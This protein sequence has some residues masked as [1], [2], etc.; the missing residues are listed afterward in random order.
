MSGGFTAVVVRRTPGTD[1]GAALKAVAD[2]D[3]SAL[4]AA[5]AAR[6]ADPPEPLPGWEHHPLLCPAETYAPSERGVAAHVRDAV[7]IVRRRRR[8]R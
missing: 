3:A 7:G 1:T 5:E 8:R 4:C 6:L 2:R